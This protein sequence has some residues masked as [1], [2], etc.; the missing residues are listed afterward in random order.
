MQKIDKLKQLEN[1]TPTNHH[2][3]NYSLHR[4]P[5]TEDGRSVLL[6]LQNENKM[7]F[8]MRMIRVENAQA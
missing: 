2:F 1:F 4:G 5:Q 7:V 8:T 6:V 3:Q